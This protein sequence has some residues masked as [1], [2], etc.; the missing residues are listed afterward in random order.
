MDKE[1]LESYNLIKKGCLVLGHSNIGYGLFGNSEKSLKLMF[2]LKGRPKTNP[3]IVI[4]NL[5]VFSDIAK[6]STETK[7][8]VEEVSKKYICAFVVPINENSN[9]IRNLSPWVREHS[10]KDNTIG[11]F[12][13]TGHFTEGLTKLGESDNLLIIGSSANISGTGNNYSLGEVEEEI[14]KKVDY[15]FDGGYAKYR[16]DEKLATTIINLSNNTLRRKG[17]FCHEIIKELREKGIIIN[18]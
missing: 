7:K 4:G 12:L 11:V 6:V 16:N 2:E 15:S 13:N 17:V 14:K 1:I 8:I 5:R 9:Y 10:T 3:S 18:S